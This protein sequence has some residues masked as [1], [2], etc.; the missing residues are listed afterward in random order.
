VSHKS[1]RQ[2]SR[3]NWG[4]A[5]M[6]ALSIEQINCGAL[7]RIADATEQMAQRHTELINARDMYKRW[8]GEGERARKHA[9]RQLAATRGVVT[10]LKKKIK[11]AVA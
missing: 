7:L 4:T 9:E 2:A 6:D 1:Y 11:E 3:A 10:K 8:Y 5:S